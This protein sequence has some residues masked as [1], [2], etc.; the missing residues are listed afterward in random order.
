MLS[1]LLLFVVGYTV[2]IVRSF[3]PSWVLKQAFGDLPQNDIQVIEHD[4]QFESIHL[5]L[6][7]NEGDFR[8]LVSLGFHKGSKEYFQN[9]MSRQHTPPWFDPIDEGAAEF[10]DG[11]EFYIGPVFHASLAYDRAKGIAYFF[12]LY[13]TD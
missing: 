12:A 2:I 5:K 13:D 10:Y 8:K 4:W 3:S 11:K 6:Q 7:A 9:S 1:V